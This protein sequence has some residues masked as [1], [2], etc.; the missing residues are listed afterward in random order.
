MFRLEAYEGR[1]RDDSPEAQV[2]NH[3]RDLW[4]SI[5]RD[6]VHYVGAHRTIK[7]AGVSA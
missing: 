4:A 2:R 7:A 1:H 6:G 3:T 5:N